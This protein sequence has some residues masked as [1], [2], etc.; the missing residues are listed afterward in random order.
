MQYNTLRK[1]KAKM[2]NRYIS[3]MKADISKAIV[4][5]DKIN[6]MKTSCNS[7]NK[8]TYHKSKRIH[9]QNFKCKKSRQIN[10]L[11]I[12]YSKTNKSKEPKLNAY[13]KTVK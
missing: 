11:K 5:I 13:I 8:T 3:D 2:D 10:S 9:Q 12:L 7:Y 4:T 6:D 1:S